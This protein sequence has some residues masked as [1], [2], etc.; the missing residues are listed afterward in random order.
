MLS[1]IQ[2]ITIPDN[3][4]QMNSR[5]SHIKNKINKR[6]HYMQKSDTH[7]SLPRMQS[8]SKLETCDPI[9]L[10]LLNISVQLQLQIFCDIKK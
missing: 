1:K 9:D 3:F 8:H 4:W 7:V 5:I 10:F 2:L 6:N